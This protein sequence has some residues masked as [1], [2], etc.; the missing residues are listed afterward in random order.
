MYVQLLEFSQC[1]SFIPKYANFENWPLSWKWL[2]IEA[3]KAQFRPLKVERVYQYIVQF[4]K[5]PPLF[6]AKTGMQIL[7]LPADSVF[8]F[9]FFLLFFNFLGV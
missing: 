5:R 4:R 8:Y 1:P 2:P 6:Y 9:F 3:K 7:N